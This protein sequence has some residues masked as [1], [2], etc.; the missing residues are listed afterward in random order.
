MRRLL[1]GGAWFLTLVASI[2]AARAGSYDALP[3][4]RRKEMQREVRVLIGL[5]E[6]IH[7]QN[8]TFVELRADE[9]L[10]SYM[11]RLDPLRL[12]FLASDEKYLR[13]RFGTTMKSSYLLAGDLY[14]AFEIHDVFRERWQARLAWVRKTLAQGL[15][16]ERDDRFEPAQEGA[17]YPGG[18]AA[19]DGAWERLLAAWLIAERL[20]G[21]DDAEAIAAVERRVDDL[22]RRIGA[23]DEET[24]SEVFLNAILELRDPHSGYHSWDSMLDIETAMAGSLAGVGVEIGREA[25]EIVVMGLTPGGAAE[26]EGSIRPGDRLA[27]LGEAEGELVSTDGLR[28]RDVLRRLRGEPGSRVQVAVERVGDPGPR[29]VTLERR[30]VAVEAAR[31]RGYL[32][33]LAG[34]GAG[35]VAGIFGVIELPAF[36]GERGEDGAV[37]TSAADDVGELVRKLRDRGMRGLVL[38]LR[39]NPG[40]RTDEAVRIAGL[41]IDTGPVMMQAGGGEGAPVTVESDTE[42]GL[43]WDGP[44]VVLTSTRSA[45]ASELVAGALQSYGRAIVVGAER[46]FGKGTA[47]TVIP[48]AD[49]ARHLGIA[50]GER[51]GM[52]RITNQMFFL[53]D[54]ASTQQRGVASDIALELPRSPDER[55]ENGLPGAFPW[56]TLPVA[57]F[58]ALRSTAVPVAAALDQALRARLVSGSA[59]RVAELPEFAWNKR[60]L[61]YRERADSERTVDLHLGRRRAERD[62]L[63]E[64]RRQLTAER[65]RLAAELDHAWTAVWLNAVVDQRDA[66]AAR[67]AELAAASGPGADRFIARG[68]FAMRRHSEQ[69]WLEMRLDRLDHRAVADEC[70]ALATAFS[71]ASGL[72]LGAASLRAAALELREDR[73]GRAAAF[74]R[75]LAAR[76]GASC[77]DPAFR[78]GQLA[79]LARLAD[80]N[81]WLV[82]DPVPLDIALREAIRVASDWAAEAA[83][84]SP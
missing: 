30:R 25:E 23:I 69:P 75:A 84:G 56:R 27:A 43:A 37:R 21:R 71:E 80:L 6:N 82:G 74:E 48:L 67:M 42:P 14:P 4:E 7:Y 64:E 81:P 66:H 57:D 61:A 32:V 79:M 28:V 47:Q 59:A 44:L 78:R 15:D 22:D 60:R 38:D 39:E 11:Q 9:I 58:A 76:A 53:P 83:A 18:P 2:P 31:A 35:G 5:L 36:Y 68:V 46:T 54:G 62:A 26:A 51:F 49:A 34:P 10:S 17:A 77:D 13:R 73:P 24:V 12:V 55:M 8:R 45:S 50:A 70:E 72:V 52:V 19:A 1:W 33:D 20:E 65:R 63:D 29:R 41:F 3:Q 40:G 16:L